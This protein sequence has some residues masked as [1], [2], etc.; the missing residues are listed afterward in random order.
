M[1][2]TI[3]D[4][5][6][7]AARSKVTFY[8][9]LMVIIIK[10]VPSLLEMIHYFP[11]ININDLLALRDDIIDWYPYLENFLVW[12]GIGTAAVASRDANKND[13]DSGV[14]HDTNTNNYN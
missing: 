3:S 9:G 13:L 11:S 2:K 6:T 5:L 10:G 4:F 7:A 14:P 12:T 8:I 1:A